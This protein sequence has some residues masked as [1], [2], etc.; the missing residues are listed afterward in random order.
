VLQLGRLLFVGRSARTNEAGV[1]QLQALVSATGDEVRSVEPGGCL[2]LKS[3]VTCVAQGT[4]LLNPD[5]VD[6][7]AFADFDCLEID[8]A[9]PFAAGPTSG[10]HGR[11]VQPNQ[12]VVAITALD[13]VILYG[14]ER[15]WTMNWK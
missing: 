14:T 7:S 10:T 13:K 9:E 15:S 1:A 6:V 5:W 2:H 3:A 8:P 11:Q 12:G 4:L